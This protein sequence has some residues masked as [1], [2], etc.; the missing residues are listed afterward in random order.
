MLFFEGE[1]RGE[2]R[3]FREYLLLLALGT[4]EV[5]H[6]LRMHQY[7]SLLEGKPIQ[8]RSGRRKRKMLAFC[9]DEVDEFNMLANKV[10]SPKRRQAHVPL[11]VLKDG[12][13]IRAPRPLQDAA[14]EIMGVLGDDGHDAATCESSEEDSSSSEA[15]E[16]D[17]LD[18]DI[19]ANPQAEGPTG[20]GAAGDSVAE[21]P[22]S[23]EG[24]VRR[25]MHV[26]MAWGLNIL[27][28]IENGWQMACEN[29][30]PNL[31]G[32]KKCKKGKRDAALGSDLCMRMV[33][34]W[35]IWGKGAPSRDDHLDCWAEVMSCQE[36]NELPEDDGLGSHQVWDWEPFLLGEP[37]DSDNASSSA[38]T[39][40][41]SQ[42]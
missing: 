1:K 12:K 27:T 13:E 33:K 23:A 30:A 16:A 32:Q 35:A 25:N 17:T 39:S 10:R 5:P 38:S 15:P 3:V 14:G 20:A 8:L 9:G 2:E 26:S 34:L 41:T 40:S 42:P 19:T 7:A 31:P 24:Q 11:K 4:Q 6:F 22:V 21:M 28:P 18:A 29:P 37:T 36:C